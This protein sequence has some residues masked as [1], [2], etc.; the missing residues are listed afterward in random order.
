MIVAVADTASAVDGSDSHRR[1]T[2]TPGADD[3]DNDNDDDFSS[4]VPRLPKMSAANEED[5][6]SYVFDED[7]ETTN[8]L[9]DGGGGGDAGS[10]ILTT[11]SE[12]VANGFVRDGSSLPYVFETNDS[13]G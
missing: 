4:A 3:I 7:N 12:S 1:Y 11:E 9:A 2:G 5:D 6:E 13:G 8:G 10:R